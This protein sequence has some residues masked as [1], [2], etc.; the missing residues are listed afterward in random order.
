MANYDLIRP[1]EPFAPRN[2][3]MMEPPSLSKE[4]FVLPI[5][6]DVKLPLGKS[7]RVVD[8]ELQTVAVSL[9]PSFEI[10]SK[11]ATEEKKELR[12]ALKG[13]KGLSAKDLVEK[14]FEK[15]YR[16][17]CYYQITWTLIR[18]EGKKK[19][20]ASKEAA[21]AEGDTITVP[22]IFLGEPTSLPPHPPT[23]PST[24]SP[25][26]FVVPGTALGDRWDVHRSTTK[27]GGP[28]IRSLRR[29]VDIEVRCFEVQIDPR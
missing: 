27:W 24:L 8:G 15:V 22:F 23:I 17:G 11:M 19:G 5:P 1:R 29:T 20:K 28:L 6:F 12:L 14:G 16:I 26:T 10:S 25:Q 4:D 2:E 13:K 9:P 21:A 3:E 18:E 7:T